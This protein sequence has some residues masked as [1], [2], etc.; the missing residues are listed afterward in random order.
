M[1]SKFR[2]V[3]LIG[4]Y[5]ATVSGKAAD[6]ARQLRVRPAIE[7]C[8]SAEPAQHQGHHRAHE[9]ERPA[10]QDVADAE[11]L[12]DDDDATQPDDAGQQRRLG[13]ATIRDE[14]P[15]ETRRGVHPRHETDE[16]N[17]AAEQKVGDVDVHPLTLC[18]R[19]LPRVT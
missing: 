1:K 3:A 8:R 12:R 2:H 14:S 18:R 11:Q 13:T 17:G 19:Q 15:R 16:K 4:K 9:R 10:A 5:H 6:S 7:R